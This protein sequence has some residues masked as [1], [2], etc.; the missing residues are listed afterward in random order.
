MIRERVIPTRATAWATAWLLRGWL[1]SLDIRFAIDDLTTVP[2]HMPRPGLYIFW[3]EM[4]LIPAYTHGRMMTTLVSRGRDGDLIAQVLGFWG[5]QAIRGSTD[6]QG[7]RALR[8][9]IRRG[10]QRHLGLT[11]DHPLGPAQVVS[12]GPIY[13]ASRGGMPLVPVGFALGRCRRAGPAGRR[14]ALPAP[15][16]RVRAVVGRPIQVPPRLG[17]DRLEAWR[18]KV[19]AAMDHAHA[20]AERLLARE[21]YDGPLFSLR[22]VL[23][24]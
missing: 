22:D 14:I 1:G 11:A 13:L 6:H 7:D 8:E 12:P 2:Q 16:G 9:L 21:R 10:R 3:H 23:T 17:R 4:L 24:M 20:R 15:F 5:G 18:R 19:Q